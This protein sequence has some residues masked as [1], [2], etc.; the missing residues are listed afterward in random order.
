MNSHASILTDGLTAEEQLMSPLRGMH[1]KAC[2]EANF[3][4]ELLHHALRLD[5]RHL[6]VFQAVL[7]NEQVRSRSFDQ[8]SSLRGRVQLDV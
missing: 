6:V 5:I 8:K 7:R 3:P 2:R 4:A 1:H